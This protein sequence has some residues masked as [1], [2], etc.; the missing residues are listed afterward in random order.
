MKRILIFIIALMIPVIGYSQNKNDSEDVKITINV[1][2]ISRGL[3]KIVNGITSEVKEFKKDIDEN[4][5]QEKKDEY[6]RQFEEL[7][8]NLKDCRKEIH[9][10]FRQGLR[11]E[12]YD[13]NK[14]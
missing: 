13:P 8:N 9:R 6:K 10:G 11:G 12:N 4:L 14:D 1:S 2:K 3:G 5:P 7:K